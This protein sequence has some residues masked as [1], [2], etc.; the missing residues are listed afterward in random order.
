MFENLPSRDKLDSFL[1][2]AE[3]VILLLL[4]SAFLDMRNVVAGLVSVSTMNIR[5]SVWF[6]GRQDF[7]LHF[8][9]VVCVFAAYNVYYPSTIFADCSYLLLLKHVRN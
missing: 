1:I 9:S 7:K 3:Q 5:C 6:V 2:F 8:G 4:G